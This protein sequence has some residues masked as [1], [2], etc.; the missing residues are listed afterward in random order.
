MTRT[1]LLALLLCVGC[2]TP[3]EADV[4]RAAVDVDRSSLEV[5]QRFD[6]DGALAETALTYT[7]PEGERALV[8]GGELL[9]GAGATPSGRAVRAF[10]AELDPEV[11]AALHREGARY[12]VAV[13]TADALLELDA[14]AQREAARALGGDG[15]LCALLEACDG[16]R[17]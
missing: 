11:L 2:A 9:T 10:L 4:Q 16:A 7:D 5:Q 14:P 3:Q 17:S 8:V 13:L 1:T 6:D 12:D 15:P